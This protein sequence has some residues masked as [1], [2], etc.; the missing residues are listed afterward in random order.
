MNNMKY[1]THHHPDPRLSTF[2][3]ISFVVLCAR[4]REREREREERGVRE[5]ERGTESQTAVNQ[6][7]LRT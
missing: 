3:Y 7:T 2:C 6:S 4:E 1:V 5:R